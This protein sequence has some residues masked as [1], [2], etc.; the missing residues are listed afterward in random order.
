VSPVALG[1]QVAEAKLRRQA[2]LDAGNPVRHPA[3][4]KLD[5][6]Q[7]AFMIKQNAVG[8]MHAETL[9]IVHGHPVSI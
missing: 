4:H 2:E 9:A 6:A 1:L 8:A 7:R 5:A 3:R